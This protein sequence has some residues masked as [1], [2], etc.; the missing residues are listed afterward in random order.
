MLS[1]RLSG[2]SSHRKKS[3]TLNAK[4]SGAL[5]NKKP[6][7]DSDFLRQQIVQFANRNSLTVTATAKCA[8]IH[9]FGGKAGRGH[10][11]TIPARPYLTVRQDG[12]LYPQEQALV[13]QVLN[14]YLMGCL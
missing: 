6:S 2:K 8:A 5:A 3:G 7:V 11:V 1:A 13:L 12:T 10:Q 9:Q 14:D 4:G